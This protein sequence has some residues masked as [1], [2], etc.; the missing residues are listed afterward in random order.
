[1]NR[2]HTRTLKPTLEILEDRCVPSAGF[3]DSTFNGNGVVTTQVG[4]TGTLANAVAVY[5]SGT[6][7][8]GK[9]VAAGQGADSKGNSD[10]AWSVTTRMGRS[11]R[12]SAREGS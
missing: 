7:N 3:L 4:S 8:A 5:P 1:M 10:S 6:A 11:T 12:P 2:K 9:I